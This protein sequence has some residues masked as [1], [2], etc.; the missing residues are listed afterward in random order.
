MKDGEEVSTVAA[1]PKSLGELIQYH[2]LNKNISLSKLQE[3]VGLDKGSLS[4]IER[5]EVKRPDFHILLSI[6]AALDIPH[7]DIVELY[8][9]IG[10]KSEVI[11]SIFQH[12]LATLEHPLLICKIAAKFLESPSEDSYDL[13][14]KLYRTIDSIENS[15]IQLSLYHLIIDYSRS[16]GIM[17]YIAKGLYRKYMIERNDFS[18]LKETYQSGKN[19]LDYVNFLSDKEKILL[20]YGLSVHAYSLIDYEDAIRFGE[21]V[22]KNGTGES[23]ANATHN[24]CNAYYHLGDFVA[25]RSYL[26]K[27]SQ[28]P[29]PFVADNVCLMNG[30][31]NGKTGNIELAISQFNAYLMDSSSYNLIHAVTELFHLYLSIHDFVSAENLLKYEDSMLESINNE[32]TTPFKRSRLAYFYL[33]KGI[34][35]FNTRR[36]EEAFNCFIESTCEYMDIGV[37]DKALVSLLHIQQSVIDN[38]P[39]PKSEL[40]QKI[41][42]LH[43]QL[44][45]KASRDPDLVSKMMAAL[46][47]AR[48][49]IP[50]WLMTMSITMSTSGITIPELPG[51]RAK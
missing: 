14:E 39:L 2:R 1:K 38:N 26:E 17:P 5:G 41:N 40:V 27:Y 29:Y 15:A 4:R 16:H 22:V 37:Y 44:C 47:W 20:Y 25:C 10:H 48:I 13:V 45:K 6:A 46:S 19:V 32:Y 28:Y 51:F 12:E 50:D 18:R 49:E 9:E 7:H 23:Q 8:I 31:I 34:M 36:C 21:Y 42:S 33:L 3:A 30:Y 11:F 24:V 43:E 35:M